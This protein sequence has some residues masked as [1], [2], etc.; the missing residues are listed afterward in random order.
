MKKG[1]ILLESVIALFLIAILL[2]PLYKFSNLFINLKNP[3]IKRA[4][5]PFEKP[6][7]ENLTSGYD[8][9]STEINDG[10]TGTFINLG[11]FDESEENLQ[12]IYFEVSATL[13]NRGYLFISTPISQYG[14]CP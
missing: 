1:F 7:K 5:L 11:L 4:E 9:L 10:K 6:V 8:S 3:Q 14:E 13:F 2:L 12:F